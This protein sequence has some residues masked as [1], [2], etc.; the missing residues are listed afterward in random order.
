MVQLNPSHGPIEPTL[1]RKINNLKIS[2]NT[3]IIIFWFFPFNFQV[4][5]RNETE[6]KMEDL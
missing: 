1:P 3:K 4:S 5:G 2:K 6:H